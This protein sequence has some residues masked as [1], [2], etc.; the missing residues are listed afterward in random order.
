MIGLIQ[1]E[2]LSSPIIQDDIKSLWDS[3]KVIIK[4]DVDHADC[5]NN[6][7][8]AIQQD[9]SDRSLRASKFNG[10]VLLMFALQGGELIAVKD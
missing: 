1:K 3:F 7:F 2:N 4:V 10:T 8:K 6:N 9:S 5:E